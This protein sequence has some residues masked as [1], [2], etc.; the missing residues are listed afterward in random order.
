MKH[1]R[2][3]ETSQIGWFV[4]NTNIR[5][6]H[7]DSNF[8]ILS[9]RVQF[10]KQVLTRVIGGGDDLRTWRQRRRFGSQPRC[11]WRDEAGHGKIRQRWVQAEA[12]QHHDKGHA[13]GEEN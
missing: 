9:S 8:L 6:H 5:Q 12:I 3:G 1:D 7:L 4:G 2:E 11:K 10:Q 13:P